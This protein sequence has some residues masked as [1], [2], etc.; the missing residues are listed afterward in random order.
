MYV[1]INLCKSMEG[2]RNLYKS[3]KK[4]GKVGYF[5]HFFGIITAVT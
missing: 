1:G 5:F 4:V 2:A 3:V